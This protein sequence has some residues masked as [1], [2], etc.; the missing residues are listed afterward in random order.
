MPTFQLS[1][2]PCFGQGGVAVMRTSGFGRPWGQR[3]PLAS[4]TSS[5]PLWGHFYL[6][7]L[8]CSSSLCK[9]K[10]GVPIMAQQVKNPTSIHEDA[11]SIPALAQWVKDPALP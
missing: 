9:K 11:G 5:N 7:H 10:A 8:W 2:S 3:G 1:L 4:W 6:F